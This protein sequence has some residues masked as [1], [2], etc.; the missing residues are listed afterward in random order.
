MATTGD[1]AVV[2]FGPPSLLLATDVSVVPV[3]QTAFA[4]SYD[5]HLKHYRWTTQRPLCEGED[6]FIEKVQRLARIHGPEFG[7]GVVFNGASH[8]PKT[9]VRRGIWLGGCEFSRIFDAV[10]VPSYPEG[11]VVLDVVSG[12]ARVC[13]VWSDPPSAASAKLE[14]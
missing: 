5:F 2:Y 4:Y 10:S 9:A 3:F 11:Q 13:D 6:R 1:L 7:V 12:L 8:A 14:F